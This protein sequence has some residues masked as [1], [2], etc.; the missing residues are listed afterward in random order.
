MN[1]I[2]TEI[3]E[4]FILEPLIFEDDRGFIFESYNEKTFQKEIGL[5]RKFVQDNHSSSN[6][7]VLRGL[8]F[9]LKQPQG[10]LIR[11]VYGEIF[12][13]AV[14]LRKKSATFG[15]WTSCILTSTNKRIFW[16]PEGFAHGFL[17]ISDKAEILYKTSD[18]YA[19]QYE[20]TLKWDDP[21]V[22]IKWPAI[23][24]ELIVSKKDQIGISLKELKNL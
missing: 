14:D 2:E 11:V 5:S 4:V 6:R 3:P 22:N 17:V 8:H 7:N 21:E 19:P 13:V 15:H 9:Q 18:F 1:I 24:G 12:D 23:S 16:I 10:K 20:K